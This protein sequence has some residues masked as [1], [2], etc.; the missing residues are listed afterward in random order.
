MKYEDYDYETQESTY[1]VGEDGGSIHGDGA[2]NVD[3]GVFDGHNGKEVSTFLQ[4]NFIQNLTTNETNTRT[5][6]EN[7]EEIDL[8]D[9]IQ[10]EKKETQ[11]LNQNI[12][13]LGLK[14]KLEIF[15]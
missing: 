13:E 15:C 5:N 12:H 9:Y 3:Y 7:N 10:S 8:K 1:L 4:E 14:H 2:N 11:S 6:N